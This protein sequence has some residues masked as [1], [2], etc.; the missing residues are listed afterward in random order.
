MSS[1]WGRA[2]AVRGSIALALVLG[3]G[4]FA[5][6]PA[7]AQVLKVGYVDSV[8]LF[9]QYTLARDAQ[10]RFGREIE[11]WRG[12]S[13]DRR[14]TIETLRAEA[15]EQTLILS[16][17]KRLEKEAQIQKALSDYDQFVQAFWGPRGRAAQLNEQLTAEVIGRVRDVVERIARD[18]GYDLVLDAAD[19]NVIFAVKSLDL[20]ERVLEI[21][22][23]E[24]GAAAGGASP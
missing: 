23:R 20:T 3:L 9:E 1:R 15:R 12:E 10:A 17:E 7:T 14:K 5:A 13:D 8:R 6:P 4:G 24:A 19:G 16:E 2:S 11:T 22:N 21:L 18:E